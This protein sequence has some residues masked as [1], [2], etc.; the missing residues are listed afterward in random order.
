MGISMDDVDHQNTQ[1][2]LITQK[3]EEE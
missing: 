1:K 3:E 2:D